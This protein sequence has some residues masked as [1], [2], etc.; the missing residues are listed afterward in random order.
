MGVCGTLLLATCVTF[1]VYLVSWWFKRRRQNMPPGPTPLPLLGNIFQL[2][3]SEFPKEIMKLS[4]TYGPVITLHLPNMRL[5]ILVGYDTVKEALVDNGDAFINR[6]EMDVL[7][8]FFNDYGIIMSNGERWKSM[9]RFSLMTLRNF[10][11]GK[12][13]IEERI[14]EEAQYLSDEFRK[15]QGTP[16]DP[17]YLLGSA[18]SNVI[19]S[20]V[21]GERFDYED[22][23]FKTLLFNLREGMNMANSG[24][25][26]LL[27]LIPKLAPYIPGPH[28]KIMK[29]FGNVKNFINEMVTTH[30]ETLDENCPRDFIDCFLIKMNEEKENPD[31][32]FKRENLLACVNDLF[33]AGTETSSI[34]LTYSYLIMLKYPNIQ[35]KVQEEIN[36]VIGQDR[37]PSVEDR[38]KMP[39]VEAVIHELQRFADIVPL[40]VAR[41]THKDTSFRGYNIPKGTLVFPALTS[42]LKDPTYFKNPQQFDP[43]HFLD[44]NGGFKKNDAFMPFSIGKRACAGEG[45]AR[46][47]IFLFLTT[48][49]QKF[50]L[51]ATEDERYIEITPEPRSNAT[52]PRPYKMYAVPRQINFLRME[53]TLITKECGSYNYHFSHVSKEAPE[54][55]EDRVQTEIVQRKKQRERERERDEGNEGETEKEKAPAR[56]GVGGTLLM[57]TCVTFVMYLVSWWFKRRREN[58]PPG[59]TPLPLLGNIFQLNAAEFPKEIMKLSETYGSVFTLHLPNMRSVILVG[60]DTVKEALVDNGDAF[61]NRGEMDVLEIFFNDYGIINTNG[62]R[63]KSMRRFSLMT[64]RNFGMGKRSIEERI[65]E[66]AQYLSDEFRK[67]QGTPFDPTY[68]LGSAVSNVICSIVFGE[69]FDYED[70][71]FKTLLFNLR[72]GMKMANS[73]SGQFFNLIPKLAPYI[74]GPHKKIMKYFGNVKNFINEMVTTHQ[75]TLDENCPRDFIDCFL[76]KMN[77]EKENPNTEFKRENLLACV[78]DLFFAGTE[79]SSI[80]LTYSYLIMLKYTN[81]QEKVQEEINRVI[82]QDRCPSVEDRSKMP[83]V[84]AVIHELQRFADIVPLGVARATHKD[85]SFRGYNIPKGTLVFPVLTSV[86]K[87]P[88]YFKNPQQFDPG[89]FL[90]E[91]GC[92]KKNDAFMPFS[93]GK[94]ACAGEGLARMEI[95]LFFTTI[96]QKFTLKATEDERYIEITPEPRSNATRPRPYKMYAVPR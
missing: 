51:K 89:H 93:I 1:L 8:I 61:I 68:L 3:A 96:L 34:T 30:Q 83:Y 37:C 19:C 9:R 48:I 95:F 69:R 5:V 59:P 86:L 22:K 20:I 62:E 82:G 91:N 75:E 28:K 33:F 26:Q 49:L 72:E 25:G 32:E 79:T 35:E 55:V 10:G 47:E 42:V 36:R 14:Q 88:K 60:Y 58:M 56:M 12:R 66:E 76:I 52:R 16:F 17:T 6:G 50:T 87:D 94:R 77:E 27:T 63:W 73:G 13:S 67:H 90:D 70:K 11:M 2:N 44:E 85:T 45:L 80:T 38:S 24:S 64:L 54:K 71:R 57:A 53:E 18:V 23:S 4:K 84:E 29:Y 39:Y 46:M 74:P 81:I 43:G 41:A 40:G 65:Q 31:T 21:F 7:E 15:H 92:F 78:S